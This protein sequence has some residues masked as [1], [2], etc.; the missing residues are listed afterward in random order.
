[1]P[2][3]KQTRD[4]GMA[5][6]VGKNPSA[7]KLALQGSQG[8]G[9]EYAKEAARQAEDDERAFW[10]RSSVRG[11]S[12]MSPASPRGPQEHFAIDV[13]QTVR[14]RTAA[15]RPSPTTK[16]R[17]AVVITLRQWRWEE[18]NAT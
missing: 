14:A 10:P 17:P 4:E 1:M 3:T 12:P 18:V 2:D 16:W 6:V 11:T 9:A 8:K 15:G 5:A 7:E 13:A